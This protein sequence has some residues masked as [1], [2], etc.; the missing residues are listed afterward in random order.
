MDTII[1]YIQDKYNELARIQSENYQRCQNLEEKIEILKFYKENPAEIREREFNDLFPDESKETYKK[2][3]LFRDW[4]SISSSESQIKDLLEHLEELISLRIVDLEKQLREIEL[5][6]DTRIEKYERVLDILREYNRDKYIEPEERK[7]IDEIINTM[8]INDEIIK[9]YFD[10]AINNSRIERERNRRARE[11]RTAVL[12]EEE[13]QQMDASREE[14]APSR[15]YDENDARLKKELNEKI[16]AFL[17]DSSLRENNEN[18]FNSASDILS[19]ALVIIN[20][21]AG[22]IS[23]IKEYLDGLEEPD[24][25]FIDFITAIEILDA[26]KNN[27]LDK[28]TS[29]IEN[30]NSIISR[31]N[32]PEI[33]NNTIENEP[34]VETIAIE[35]EVKSILN[36]NNL[37]EYAELM[38][39][40]EELYYVKDLLDDPYVKSFADLEMAEFVK[41]IKRM[42]LSDEDNY[43]YILAKYYSEIVE[44]S[45]GVI[46]E[47]TKNKL[48][49][50]KTKINEIINK[51]NEIRNNNG[52][53]SGDPENP[54][55]SKFNNYIVFFNEDEFTESYNDP[56]FDEIRPIV[57]A[58]LDFKLDKL[59]EHDLNTIIHDSHVLQESESKPNQDNLYEYLGGNSRITYQILKTSK[60]YRDG[61]NQEHGVIIVYHA[62]FAHQDKHDKLHAAIDSF[63]KDIGNFL[64][65]AEAFDSPKSFESLCKKSRIKSLCSKRGIN[66]KNRRPMTE[67]ERIKF[68]NDKIEEGIRIWKSIKDQIPKNTNGMGEL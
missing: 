24:I 32:E 9:F 44:T 57:P 29:I 55:S 4:F 65:F 11:E 51:I 31:E 21:E 35:D 47:E 23:F 37:E 30:Y 26:Y 15:E 17:E 45:Y 13:I 58:V 2:I 52:S 59:V 61:D 68:Q 53:N 49:E 42:N 7:Q 48:G 20:D 33:E 63:K 34:V 27:D 5:I 19:K 3:N 25:D 14:I 67:N 66:L 28:I 16:K 10:I 43:R 1:S 54:Y 12:S 50:I 36:S 6:P 8:S 40:L 60:I 18:L 56:T 62:C 39:E 38:V 46:T 41:T 64:D 22:S